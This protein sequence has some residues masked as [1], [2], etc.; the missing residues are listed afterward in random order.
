M[1]RRELLTLFGGAAAMW[2]VAPRAQQKLPTI[3]FFGTTSPAAWRPWT[4]AFLQRL[5]ELG[6]IEGRTVAIEYRWAEGREES[7][8][9]I[10]AEFVRLKVDVVVTAGTTV[11]V[12][13]QATSVIPIVFAI[14]RDPLGEGS[15][16]SLARPGGNATGLSTQIA[17]VAGKRLE[18]M[19]DVSPGVR[20]LAVLTE[21]GEP[22]AQLERS[23]VEAAARKLGVETVALE[24]R[25]PNEDIEAAFEAAKGRAD[26]LYAG[27]GP[28][29]SLNRARIFALALA[30]KLPTISG[31]RLDAQAGGLMSY[32]PD[33]ADLFRR[34]GDY[35]DKILRGAK[36]DE[37]PVEQ[38]V[39]FE[40]VINLKTAKAL[41]LEIPSRLLFTANEVIE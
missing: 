18:L 35:V 31:L 19:R 27:S 36:P 37:L 8:A 6:W 41:G 26:A 28:L 13:R 24:I 21:V 23:Q 2:P 4:A 29:T 7:F 5:R 20:K 14:S 40:L 39:K 11:P 25:H 32:G 1:R 30:R 12:L 17:D 16:K 10:A 3:G 22:A 15:V 33:Y 38:P 34:T 9:A